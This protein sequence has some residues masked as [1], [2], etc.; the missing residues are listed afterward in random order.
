MVHTKE[1]GTWLDMFLMVLSCSPLYLLKM[2]WYDWS[3][4]IFHLKIRYH[5]TCSL[6]ITI[7]WTIRTPPAPLLKCFPFSSI[8]DIIVYHFKN[9]LFERQ[10]E[11][12]SEQSLAL[13]HW[14]TH[15]SLQRPELD[16]TEAGSQELNPKVGFQSRYSDLWCA[17]FLKMSF[18]KHLKNFIS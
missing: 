10:R 11:R 7:W 16:W 17:Q 14:P 18:K 15:K 9:Y 2:L 4:C 3:S 1:L 13:I 12:A 5:V 6:F 8:S